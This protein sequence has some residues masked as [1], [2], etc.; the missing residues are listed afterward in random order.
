VTGGAGI[1]L[2]AVT[3]AVTDGPTETGAAPTGVALA[4]DETS[5]SVD[6]VPIGPDPI[7]T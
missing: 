5:D 2:C 4:E 1:A 7:E 3:L 6:P